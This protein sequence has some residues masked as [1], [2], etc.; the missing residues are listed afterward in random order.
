MQQV[1][2][3]VKTDPI[4]KQRRIEDLSKKINNNQIQIQSM[5]AM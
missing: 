3:F 2:N 4:D 5:A 1:A